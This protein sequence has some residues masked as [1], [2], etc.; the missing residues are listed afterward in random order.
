MLMLFDP[1]LA[2]FKDIMFGRFGPTEE[3]FASPKVFSLASEELLAV[4]DWVRI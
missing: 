2:K 3:F 4:P 1:E